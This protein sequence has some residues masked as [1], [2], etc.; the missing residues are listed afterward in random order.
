MAIIKGRPTNGNDLIKADG[1]D[2]YI[3]AK[4]GNDTVY[5]GAGDDF[6]YGNDGNDVLYGGKG[7]D[8]LMGGKGNDL[9][10]GSGGDYLG[11]GLGDD[12]LL[13]E[14][15]DNVLNGGAGDD[16]IDGG[17]G[18]DTLILGNNTGDYGITDPYNFTLTNDSVVGE[19]NDT[20]KSIEKASFYGAWGDDLFDASAFTSGKVY[21]LGDDGNDTLLGGAGDDYFR[22]DS[23]NDLI[24]GG[25]G[26]DRLLGGYGNDKIDGGAGDDTLYGYG[27]FFKYNSQ[28]EVKDTLTGGD[29]ADL[30]VL[31]NVNNHYT[32]SGEAT[33]TDFSL[34]EGDKIQLYKSADLYD[35]KLGSFGGSSSTQDTGIYS[36]NDLIAVVNDVNLIGS[37]AFTY[38]EQRE[39]IG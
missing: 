21:A 14:A 4:A 15:G 32:G 39:L 19:G 5:G 37:D 29:G 20:L 8:E 22:G 27:R 23:G 16:Y 9:L 35:L 2:D 6:I 18:T 1:A 17:E 36:G 3:S 31:G 34:A 38:V 28:G 10:H 7:R 13:G 11:G 26:N 24:E 33:I 12:T 25:A 30:F